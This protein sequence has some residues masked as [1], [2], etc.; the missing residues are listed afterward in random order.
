MP[1]P[2]REAQAVGAAPE[3][4]ETAPEQLAELERRLAELDADPEGGVLE[5][6]GLSRRPK[7]PSQAAGC[8]GVDLQVTVG[9]WG[10]NTAPIP[11]RVLCPV[12]GQFPRTHMAGSLDTEV[13]QPIGD[14]RGK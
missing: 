14:R 8:G 4:V 9:A 10:S 13:H 12:L 6:G 2:A 11:P 5:R 1:S 3:Q 7:R